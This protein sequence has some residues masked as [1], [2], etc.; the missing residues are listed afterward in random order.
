MRFA[1]R[2]AAAVAVQYRNGTA[3]QLCGFSAPVLPLWWYG[4]VVRRYSAALQLCSTAQQ[5]VQQPLRCDYAVQGGTVVRVWGP[6]FGMS[7]TF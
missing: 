3:V 7:F 2:S 6:S 1:V 4:T 5:A